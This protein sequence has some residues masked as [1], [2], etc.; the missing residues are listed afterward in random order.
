ML[1]ECLPVFHICYWTRDVILVVDT[2]YTILLSRS[3]YIQHHSALVVSDIKDD[4]PDSSGPPGMASAIPSSL[5]SQKSLSTS[6]GSLRSIPDNE[7]STTASAD[8]GSHLEPQPRSQP[9]SLYPGSLLPTSLPSCRTGILKVSLR[10]L[11]CQPKG[12]IQY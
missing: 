8:E 7:S 1:S 12:G 10:F 9:Q 3:I 2:Q 4:K 5:T 6:E 11:L